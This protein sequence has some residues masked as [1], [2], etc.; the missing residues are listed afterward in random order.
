MQVLNDS[1]V[2]ANTQTSP[3]EY[4]LSAQTSSSNPRINGS[5]SSE[6]ETSWV[7]SLKLACVVLSYVFSRSMVILLSI[8][9]VFFL[10]GMIE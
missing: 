2:I 9:V 1:G 8:E 4:R 5:A 3:L 6:K 10:K 7:S